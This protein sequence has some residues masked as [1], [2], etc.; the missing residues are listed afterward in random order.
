LRFQ[1]AGARTVHLSRFVGAFRVHAD[2]KTTAKV[3]IGLQE[4]SRLRE[5]VHGRVVPVD[6]L[7]RCLRQYFFR[8]RLI[9]G[10]Q[11]ILDRL[12]PTV[13]V[14]TTPPPLASSSR[15]H[16]SWPAPVSQ[17]VGEPQPHIEDV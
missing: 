7:P 2:Q 1:A 9:H 4:M 10:W 11:R 13:V 6:E 12:P 5:R 15:S 14:E 16:A 17:R 8:H 3:V